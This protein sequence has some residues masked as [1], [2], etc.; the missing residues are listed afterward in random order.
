MLNIETITTSVTIHNKILKLARKIINN[1][2][3]TAL[4]RALPT[5]HKNR[6]RYNTVSYNTRYHTALV[7]MT[8]YT[9]SLLTIADTSA[10]LY[11]QLHNH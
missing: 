3:N 2:Q 4:S 9:T 11:R 1:K 10:H 6:V 7:S 8:T 5:Y